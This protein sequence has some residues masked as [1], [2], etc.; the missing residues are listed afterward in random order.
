METKKTTHLLA[1]KSGISHGNLPPSL[2]LGCITSLTLTKHPEWMVLR[3]YFNL[4]QSFALHLYLVN[5]SEVL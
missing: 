5:T 1:S 4:Q 2:Q 3:R